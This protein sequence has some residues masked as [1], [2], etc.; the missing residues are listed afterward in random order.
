MVVV[1]IVTVVVAMVVS[2]PALAGAVAR[3]ATLMMPPASGLHAMVPVSVA[4][5]VAAVVVPAV[6]RL[7]FAPVPRAGF[8]PPVV[9]VAAITVVPTVTVVPTIVV[10]VTIAVDAM[11]VVVAVCT[12]VALAEEPAPAVMLPV[13]TVVGIPRPRTVPV[14]AHPDVAESGPAPVAA[15]PEE[16][17]A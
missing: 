1:A 6:V 13:R 14:T 11:A 12:P 10:V 7:V 16:S 4:M 8:V 3:M 9:S 5:L 15:G 17:G 2:V